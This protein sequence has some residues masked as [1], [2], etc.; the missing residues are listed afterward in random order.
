[1]VFI[2]GMISAIESERQGE[3]IVA[4]DRRDHRVRPHVPL[5]DPATFERGWAALCFGEDT[6]CAAAMERVAVQAHRFIRSEFAVRSMLAGQPGASQ[7]FTAVMVP[8][9]LKPT[10]AP[11]SS[12]GVV[13]EFSAES[14][15]ARVPGEADRIGL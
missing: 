9:D 13:E 11:P 1:M 7:R 15:G 6:N 3:V 14:A 12:S 10:L 8:P 5:P 2:D 4:A